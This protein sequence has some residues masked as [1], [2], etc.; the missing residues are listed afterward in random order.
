MVQQDG[1]INTVRTALQ[2]LGCIQLDDIEVGNDGRFVPLDVQTGSVEGQWADPRPIRR[3]ALAPPSGS[4]HP[5]G[6]A[7]SALSCPAIG[8]FV[9]SAAAERGG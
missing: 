4:I 6:R 9:R 7:R 5:L 3:D 1:D 8:T 2:R